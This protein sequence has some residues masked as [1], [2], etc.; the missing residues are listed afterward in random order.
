MKTPFFIVSSNNFETNLYS[1][2]TSFK[3]TYLVQ[4]YGSSFLK[5]LTGLKII[6]VCSLAFKKKSIRI[7]SANG[8]RK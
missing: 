3:P 8:A 6:E 4:F 7:I 1:P 2:Q 5:K